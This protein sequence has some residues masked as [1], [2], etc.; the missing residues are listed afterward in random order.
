MKQMFFYVSNRYP[1]YT[2]TKNGS[3]LIIGYDALGVTTYD[4]K[5][6]SYQTTTRTNLENMIQQNG[7]IFRTYID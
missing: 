5:S 2:E 3:Y 6:G 4:Q 7:N 1:V